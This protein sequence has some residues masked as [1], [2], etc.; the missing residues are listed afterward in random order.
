M[1]VFVAGATGVLGRRVVR[2]LLEAGHQV[3]GVA[4]SPEKA[5]QME[6][7]GPGAMAVELDLFDAV[8]VRRAVEGSAAVCNLATHIPPLSQAALP[9]A[10][11]ENDRI[12]TEV[13][14]N[15]VDAALAGHAE[16]YVQESIV[17]VYADGADRWLDEDSPVDA[18]S[19][20]RSVLNAEAEAC[21]FTD[22]GGAGVVL[23]FGMFY[24]PDSSHTRAMVRAARWR[25]GST[26]GSRAGY[27][28]TVHL[29]DAAA[30]VVASLAVPAGVYNV[31]DDVP[32]TNKEQTAVL[33]A[34]VGAKRLWSPVRLAGAVGGNL[35]AALSRSQRVSNG[36]FKSASSWAPRYPSVRQGWPATVEAMNRA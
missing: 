19:Y 17:F 24:G 2:L 35:T 15:L 6:A 4:R 5:R 7:S 20:T 13:S 1:R 10:W 30:A 26:V 8:A 33:A 27:S 18:R 9:G 11:K 3:T 16:R 32:L 36:R 23:R 14:R 12:R 29:D 25:I 28:S 34:A 21:R 31:V 22:S